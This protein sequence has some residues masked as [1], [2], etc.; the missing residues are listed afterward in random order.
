MKKILIWVGCFL[1]FAPFSLQSQSEAIVTPHGYPFIRHTDKGGLRPQ[2]G[3]VV[4]IHTYV[5]VDD[6]LTM[7]SRIEFKQGHEF[8]LCEENNLPKQVPAMYDACL[9]MGEGDSAAVIEPFN[10]R[11]REWF[12]FDFPGAKLVRYE[13]V[14]LEVVTKE[15][16]RKAKA[17]IAARSKEVA[18]ATKTVL[19]DYHAGLLN[20]KLV[21][22]DSGIEVYIVDKG[23]GNPIQPLEEIETNHYAMLKDGQVFHN[24]FEENKPIKFTIQGRFHGPPYEADIRLLPHGGKAYFFFP[25][26]LGYGNRIP[27]TTPVNSE[28]IYYVEV[29]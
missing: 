17:R 14:M 9:L 4:Y 24:S 21:R 1:A 23:A 16:E 2:P 8:R 28:F 26:E 19:A 5:Y 12:P 20:D 18:S 29:L 15:G 3:E 27:V 10:V 13:I 25:A 7:T 22:T 6:S 11:L